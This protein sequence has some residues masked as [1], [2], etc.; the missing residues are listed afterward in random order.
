MRIVVVGDMVEKLVHDLDTNE[1]YV[2]TLIS[3][4]E[5]VGWVEQDPS[6]K[7]IITNKGNSEAHM[8]TYNKSLQLS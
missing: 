3:I 5:D 4:L 7:Y 2:S 8:Y 1:K 6:G